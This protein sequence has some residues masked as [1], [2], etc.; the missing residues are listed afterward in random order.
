MS[1]TAIDLI[2]LNKNVNRE[3]NNE[4]FENNTLAKGDETV[5]SSI[6]R[7]IDNEALI[8]TQEFDISISKMTIPQ[9][10]QILKQ[11][12]I[13]KSGN[14]QEIINRIRKYYDT[15]EGLELP[16]VY[17]ATEKGEKLIEETN[18]LN[19]FIYYTSLTPARAYY[20]ANN[21]VDE[22]VKDKIEAIYKFEIKRLVNRDDEIPDLI[23]MSLIS[24]YENSKKD[25]DNARKYK[26]ILF[27]LRLENLINEL[28]NIDSYSLFYDIEDR[29]LKY[30]YIRD[31]LHRCVTQ[32]DGKV[33][34]DLVF[35]KEL[36]TKK[37]FN[38][39]KEDISEFINY[40]NWD[41]HLYYYYVELIEVST[42]KE[43]DEFYYSYLLDRLE[44]NYT[45]ELD[46]L[47]LDYDEEFEI[48]EE[49]RY[50]SLT[51]DELLEIKDDIKFDVDVENGEIIPYLDESRLNLYKN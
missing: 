37:L 41:S 22:E 42:K 17:K 43:D 31:S 1:L 9:L 30:D 50:I 46:K 33:Y 4:I 5:L 16:T 14:K 28:K 44:R 27:Y 26:N 34:E 19:E 7:L 18:Y 47:E 23:I 20:I 15:I 49:D 25:V 2:L 3:V 24:Y 45:P 40:D 36:T 38:L 6:N 48:A 11:N 35:N 21:Y 29:S 12:G 39:F 51:F 8:K 10:K 13:K 32:I